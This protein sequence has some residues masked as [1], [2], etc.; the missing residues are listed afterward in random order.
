MNAATPGQAAYEARQ[1][2]KARRMGAPDS[3]PD[4]TLVAIIGLRW[5]ELPAGMQ[6]D[7]EAAAQAAIAAGGWDALAA[8]IEA[9]KPGDGI[10]AG[11]TILA[12][13]CRAVAARLTGSKP[14]GEVSV[15]IDDE[16]DGDAKVTVAWGAPRNAEKA[17]RGE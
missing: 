13:V 1:A 11:S 17:V 3:E 4:S 5:E 8:E 15:W 6:A 14:H 2:A 10:S 7:E 9:L 16:G 12:Q